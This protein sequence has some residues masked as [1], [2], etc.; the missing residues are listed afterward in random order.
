MSPSPHLSDDLLQACAT[1][2]PSAAA[3]AHLRACPAC[4]AWVHHYQ[5][6]FAALAEA[7]RPAFGFDLAT[8]VLAQLPAPAAPPTPARRFPG[9]ALLLAGLLPLLVAAPVAWFWGYF[10]GL[11]HAA[12]PALLL[13][14]LPTAA[15][16][17]L[18]LAGE[19]LLTHRRQ[20]AALR[21]A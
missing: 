18:L 4:R 12:A 20:L 17:L 9:W 13:V 10:V 14:G 3:A 8:A 5:A 1:A 19:T 11:F 7:P 21:P 15:A 16:L 6:L 2:A